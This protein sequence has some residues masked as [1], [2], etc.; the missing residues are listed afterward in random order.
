VKVGLRAAFPL[1]RE[2]QGS[3]PPEAVDEHH[4]AAHQGLAHGVE[5]RVQ[6]LI[7]LGWGVAKSLGEAPHQDGARQGSTSLAR[8]GVTFSCTWHWSDEV[9]SPKR[10]RDTD[11]STPQFRTVLHAA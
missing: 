1:R 11:G 3:K 6:G 5:H 9:R 4:A 8:H 7:H 10:G 2:T